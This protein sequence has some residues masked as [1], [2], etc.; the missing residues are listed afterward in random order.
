[1]TFNARCRHPVIVLD[2]IADARIPEL[3]EMYRRRGGPA[4]GTVAFELDRPAIHG[5]FHDD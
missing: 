1:V 4:D 2:R 3:V 5:R